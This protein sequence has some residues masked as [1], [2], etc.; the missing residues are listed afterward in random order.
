MS[1]PRQ[2]EIVSPWD[3]L[4]GGSIASSM[5]KSGKLKTKKNKP[6]TSTFM[7]GSSPTGGWSFP[8]PYGGSNV[9]GL[10]GYLAQVQQTPDFADKFNIDDEGSVYRATDKFLIL[11]DN[12]SKTIT[13]NSI[14]LHNDFLVNI[15]NSASTDI[16]S[17]QRLLI[18]ANYLSSKH[19]VTGKASPEYLK[20]A[21]DAAIYI[22]GMNFI[23]YSGSKTP[24]GKPYSFV[25]GLKSIIKGG[26]GGGFGGPRTSK[27][28]SVMEFTDAEARGIL[29][30]F[31]AD[32][33][34]RRPNDKEVAKFK[35]VINAEA[36][37]RPSTS[38]TTYS[39]GSS[40]TKGSEGYSQA[41]AELAARDMAES[42]PGANAFITSTKYMDT[43]LNILGGKVGRL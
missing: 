27:S 16:A 39:A 41:D 2:P 8:S 14:Q 35:D 32:A 26:G 42:K 29:E 34:G 28:I 19:G 4:T 5:N 1:D 37:K 23:N 31:Y 20:A 11:A 3:V 30:S 18:K 22:S 43:F 6:P 33:L 25:S 10:W 40:V 9:F 7:G 13:E 15:G 17:M 24:N 36:A 12:T 21:L 38:T